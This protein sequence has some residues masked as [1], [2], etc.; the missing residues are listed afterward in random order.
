MCWGLASG[1]EPF[2]RTVVRHELAASTAVLLSVA[3]I[4]TDWCRPL[5]VGGIAMTFGSSNGLVMDAGLAVTTFALAACAL[6]IAVRAGIGP[7]GISLSGGDACYQVWRWLLARV[8]TIMT[9]FPKPKPEPQ[10]TPTPTPVPVPTPPPPS[11]QCPFQGIVP[12]LTP[13]GLQHVID[14]HGPNSP[15]RPIPADGKFVTDNALRLGLII[16]EAAVAARI[17]GRTWQL[18]PNGNCIIY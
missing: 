18:Q 3:C 12:I 16:E 2:Q 6:D 10:P 8:K 4:L 14:M 1:G 7:P 15:P 13:A 5:F 17:A 11:P 9:V